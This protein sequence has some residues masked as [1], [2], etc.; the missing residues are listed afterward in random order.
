MIYEKELSIARDVALKA[1]E[2]QLA[3]QTNL[4][5]IELKSDQSPV[6]EVDKQCEQ[7]IRDTLCK[8]FPSDGFFGEETEA[9]QGTSGRRWIVD[10]LDGTRPY[11]R[12]IPTYSVLIALEIDSDYA[13]GVVHFPALSETYWAS[14]GQGAFCN[15]KPIHVSQT[16]EIRSVMGSSLGLIEEAETEEGKKLLSFMQRW[17]YNYGFM[18]ALSYMYC[19]AGKLDIC[20]GLIDKP[21]DRAAAACIVTEAGGKYSDLSGNRTIHN[22]SFVVSNGI[23]HNDIIAHFSRNPHPDI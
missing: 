18:D 4:L 10:P 13:I 19:A 14:S 15:D 12:G 7:L 9:F 1:G 20:I 6:T 22:S 3:R 16:G 17:G 21:W 11:I 23:I 8:T 5:N 2:I